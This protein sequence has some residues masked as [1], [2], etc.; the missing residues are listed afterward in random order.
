[1]TEVPSI[2]I[3][4]YDERW[5]VDFDHLAGLLGAALADVAVRVDHIG[6]TSVPGLAAKDVIDIQL[7]VRE[8]QDPLVDAGFAALGATPTEITTDHV[9]P[10]G[11][12]DPTEWTKRY[13][14]PPPHVATCSPARARGG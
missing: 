10:G 6:S 7:T 12:P 3:Q 9:P 2:V 1:M 14:R 5:P 4:P 13:F 11:S 8:L